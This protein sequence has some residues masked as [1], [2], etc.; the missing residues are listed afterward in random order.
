MRV[1]AFDHG[2]DILRV[3][4]A[5]FHVKLGKFGLTVGA[6]VLVAEAAGH[7][8]IL[9]QPGQHQKLL[10]DLRA[11]RQSVEGAG[12]DA[13]GHQIVARAFGGGLAQNGRFHLDKA[14]L[15]HEIAQELDH[16]VPEEQ[17]ALHAGTAQVQVAVFQAQAFLLLGIVLNIN[18]GRFAGVEDDGGLRHDLDLAGL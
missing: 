9:V 7:L 12:L 17:H 6:A 11:L 13:S 1:C 18:R 3:D 8:I 2:L 16:L 14:L 4:E 15:V 10:V 5:H